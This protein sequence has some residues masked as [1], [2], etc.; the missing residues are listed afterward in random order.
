[1]HNLLH[2]KNIDLENSLA[3]LEKQEKEL[4]EKE[5]HF[6]TIINKLRE[7]EIHVNHGITDFPQGFILSVEFESGPI[8][9]SVSTSS[10]KCVQTVTKCIVI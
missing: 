7:A 1:M 4:T 3:K 9:G 10:K 5:L 2:D 8:L 6:R